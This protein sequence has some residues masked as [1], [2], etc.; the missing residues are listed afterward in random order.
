M[1][2]YASVRVEGLTRRF[3]DRTVLDN[4]DVDIK[5]GEF[6]AMLGRSGSG[7]S[8][9]LRA[10][11]GIDHDH[12][13]D[14]S[15]RVPARRSVLFQ[16]AR[17]LPWATLL[18][19]VLLG[20]EEPNAERAKAVLAEVGLK[21][22]EGDWPKTLSGGEQQRVALARSL[23]R[24]PELLL[25]DEPFSALDALTKLQMQALLADICKRHS[26]AVLLVTHDVEE[27]L[28]LADRI[29]VLDQGR[30]AIAV[31]IEAPRPRSLSDLEIIELR[32]KILRQLGVDPAHRQVTPKAD[33]HYA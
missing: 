12:D 15:I 2:A 33:H 27:A 4:L 18:N 13:G 22:R 6:V 30:I 9:F 25:A 19:N 3:G 20:T 16:D 24:E 5:S 7:K 10:L 14:G 28:M 26:P 31:R 11:A 1:N 8:T 21:G 32:E 29:L 23:I 17:L